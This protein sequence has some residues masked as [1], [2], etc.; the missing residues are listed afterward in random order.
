MAAGAVGEIA[1][2]APGAVAGMG[3]SLSRVL[4]NDLHSDSASNRRN[5]AFACGTLL[6]AA[7][8]ELAAQL[9]ALLQVH[10]CLI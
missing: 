9:P 6:Q 4:V 10:A 1:R 7:P 8:R 3:E 2:E 5:A